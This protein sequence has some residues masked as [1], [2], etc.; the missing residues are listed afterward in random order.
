MLI[1]LK[2]QQ[3]VLLKI[4]IAELEIA[5]KRKLEKKDFDYYDV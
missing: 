5:L 2:V 1:T 4:R 3:I